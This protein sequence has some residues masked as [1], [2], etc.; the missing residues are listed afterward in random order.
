MQTG[1]FW[2]DIARKY[3]GLREIPGPRH[4]RTIQQW[5]DRLGLPWS[6]DET[7]WCGTYV[8]GVLLEAGLPVVKGPAGAR[9]W[10]K[11]PVE[12][13]RPA[14]GCVVVFWRGS[15]SGWQGHVGF[16]VGRDRHGN[17]MVLG[18]N[19]KNMVRIDPFSLDR[20]LGYRWPS[21]WP[22]PE[23]FD[24]P[25]LDSDGRPSSNEA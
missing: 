23:R 10:L 13:D 11:L 5:L 20:V 19:Q 22:N 3:E 14:V 2:L 1:P 18:G 9:N 4:N 17:L 24:L 6:D 8:G 7:A 12:L 21:V 25:L 16:V 15:R